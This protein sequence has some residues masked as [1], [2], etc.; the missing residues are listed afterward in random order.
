MK[1]T[2]PKLQGI[3]FKTFVIQRIVE[4]IEISQ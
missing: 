1:L 2:M 4:T 3:E